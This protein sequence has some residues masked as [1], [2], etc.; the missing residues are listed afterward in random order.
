LALAVNDP[1]ELGPISSDQTLIDRDS[2][3][4]TVTESV[5]I[6]VQVYDDNGVDLTGATPDA[7]TRVGVW[8]RDNAG[9]VLVDNIAVTTYSGTAP[10]FTFTYSWN[11]PDTL[12]DAG[13][14]QISVRFEARDQAGAVATITYTT[15]N[16]PK[17]DDLRI[18]VENVWNPDYGE[19]VI[20]EGIAKRFET[21]TSLDGVWL[22]DPY[23]GTIKGVIENAE[24]GEFYV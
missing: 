9:N 18:S 6:S 10:T 7:V 15:E 5:Q 2:D 23:E 19:E 24:T 16:V 1:V 3:W 4:T 8:I 22:I 12:T 11:P 14:G 21:T 17:V 20:F 13:L